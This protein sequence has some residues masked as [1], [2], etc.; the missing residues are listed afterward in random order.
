MKLKTKILIFETI[1][2]VISVY[3]FLLVDWKLAVGLFLYELNVGFI[4]I[5]I[6][7]LG[8]WNDK[9]RR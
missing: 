5:R 3:L 6:I 4:L 8:A 9:Q 2:Y 1:C 7:Y